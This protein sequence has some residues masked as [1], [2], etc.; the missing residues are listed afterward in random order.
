MKHID[1]NSLKRSGVPAKRVL[2]IVLSLVLLLGAVTPAMASGNSS[3]K[4]EVIYVNLAADGS[5]KDVY[6]VNIFGGGDVTDYGDY[7][8]V[9]MLNTTDAIT[10]DGDRITFSSTADRV[11]YQGKMKSTVIPWVIS[12]Q[13]F[14]DGEEYSAD[15]VAGKSG[16]L[17]IRFKVTKNGDCTGPFFDDYALQAAFTLDTETCRNITASGAALANVGGKKQIAYTLLPGEGIDTVITADVTDFEMDAV[18]INGVPL[19]MSIQVDDEELMD[20]VTE[21]LDAIA[22]LDNGAG[23]LQN[24]VSELQDGAK[25]ELVPGAEELYNGTGELRSGA[26]DLKKGGEALQDGTENL[27]TG[28]GELAKGAQALNDGVVLL[29]SGLDTLNGKSSDLTTGSAAIQEAFLTIQRELNEV[30]ASSDEIDALVSGS[31]QIKS[32]I[33]SLTAGAAALQ[34]SVSY[35]AYKTALQQN[36]LSIDELQ[37]ANVQTVASLQLQI[38]ALYEQAAYLEQM[39]GDA[40]QIGQLRASAAQLQDVVT[41]LQGNIAAING[42]ETYFTQVSAGVEELTAGINNLKENYVAVDVG[43]NALAAEVKNLLFDL[44]AL[45]SGI[46]TLVTEYGRLDS[47]INEY[48]SGVAQVV[49]GYAEI[50]DGTGSL[51]TGSSDLKSGTDALYSK[52]GELLGGIVEFYDAAGTLRDGTG[53]LADGVRELLDGI[54]G[55]YD[56]ATELKDGTAEMREETDGM[57]DEISDKID[58]MIE[59]ITGGDTEIVSFVSEKNT[60]VEAVQFV[61]QTE[62]VKMEEPEPPAA[63]EAEE[64]TLW[65]KLL[66]LFGLE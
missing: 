37:S 43:I 14:I 1:K 15:E 26:N 65:Q 18:S 29:Q 49:A 42:T 63:E 39:G 62:A 57:D 10:Q 60:K 40:A 47:G 7:S 25:N 27:K 34:G 36:G 28:A 58:E 38:T 55:L 17:E 33:D 50:V 52:T 56:G 6:A 32:G 53:E 61:L 44:T 46:D 5:V 54:A 45:K 12:I 41:L 2:A 31:S 21:L 35:D 22:E 16:R 64:L 51:L 20:R 19:S 9:Q 24:G 4:E 30:S 13:Y 59:S 23:E 8:A 66:Q 11:Y 48:T 3:E